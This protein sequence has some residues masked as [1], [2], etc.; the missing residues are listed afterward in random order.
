KNPI[1]AFSFEID[2]EKQNILNKIEQNNK[3]NEI[4]QVKRGIELGQVTNLVECSN[5][6]KYTEISTKY[7]SN[8]DVATLIHTKNKS[9]SKLK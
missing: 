4:S 1:K 2:N 9:Y 6:N 8:S 7:Y 5:C 3:I